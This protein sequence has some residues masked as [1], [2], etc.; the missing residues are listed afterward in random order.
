[1]WSGPIELGLLNIPITIGKA[2]GDLA[3]YGISQVD[4]INGTAYRI[5][6]SERNAKTGLPV[7]NKQ[8]AIEVEEN[9]W[10]IID[11]EEWA[12]IENAT[13]LPSLTVLDVVPLSRL[14]LM[15]STGTYYVRHDD[16]AKVQPKAFKALMAALTKERAG[17][18]CK[19]GNSARQKLVVIN[20]ERGIM[21]LRT[22]PFLTDIRVAS[23]RERAHFAAKVSNAE[24]EKMGELL[25]AIADPE[26][27]Q[28]DQYQDEGV[29]LRSV[30]IKRILDGEEP[31]KIEPPEQKQDDFNIF[32]AIDAALAEVKA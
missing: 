31:E 20:A 13:K 5:D 11:S 19:W 15:Y 8:R 1:M 14:P 30:A 18:V 22:I 6:R 9:H 2:T 29:A 32:E 7:E 23:K 17:L 12:S 25:N 27:F 28:Y 21:I 26:G 16:K 24:V 4:V 10:R 3:D